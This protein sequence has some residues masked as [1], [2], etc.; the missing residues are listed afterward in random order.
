MLRQGYIYMLHIRFRFCLI[1]Q[2]LSH[3]QTFR[4][5][6]YVLF[7]SSVC[8]RAFRYIYMH[9]TLSARWNIDQQLAHIIYVHSTLQY[10]RY[11]LPTLKTMYHNS[12]LVACILN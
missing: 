5:Q 1:D 12:C 11:G 6:I 8:F 4:L 3:C 7:S 2:K 9:D 10:I